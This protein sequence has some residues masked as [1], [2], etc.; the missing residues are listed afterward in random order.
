VVQVALTEMGKL[1]GFGSFDMRPDWAA[2]LLPALVAVGV[3][4]LGSVVPGR[5]AARLNVVEVLQYE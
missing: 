3:G 1:F 5:W 2:L 4:I